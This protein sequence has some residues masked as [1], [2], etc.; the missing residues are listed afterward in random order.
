[1]ANDTICSASGIAEVVAIHS[2][3]RDW[4]VLRRGWEGRKLGWE[5][6]GG[7]WEGIV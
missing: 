1:M 2:P 5:G 4:V 7:V 3:K 6:I